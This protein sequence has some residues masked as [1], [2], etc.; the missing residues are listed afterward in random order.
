MTIDHIVLS[1]KEIK[2]LELKFGFKYH[3][4]T[5]MILFA[6]VLYYLDTGF[7][8]IVLWKYNY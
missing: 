4:A 5:G 2:E 6:C 8:I 3:T 1:D 7:L